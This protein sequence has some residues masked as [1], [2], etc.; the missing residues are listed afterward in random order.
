MEKRAIMFLCFLFLVSL[1][2]PVS[3]EIILSQPDYLYTIGDSLQSTI[4][5]KPV[6]PTNDFLTV[7]ISCGDESVE[8][9]KNQ[10][11]IGAGE[12]QEVSIN[13]VLSN[14]VV[15]QLYGECN[16][17]A[18]FG[19]ESAE[20]QIFILSREIIV[21]LELE[22]IK[23][24]PKEE[25]R[26]SGTAV[27]INGKKIEGFVEARIE[28]LGVVVS[29]IIK[30]GSFN[31]ILILPE[32][33]PAG[34]Y[35]LN[36]KAYDKDSLD[37]IGNQGNANQ[38]I[39]VASVLKSLEIVI[40][41]LNSSF[42]KEI[43]YSV[44]A[45]DQSGDKLDNKDISVTVYEPGDFEYL[46]QVL[47]SGQKSTIKIEKN[48]T[49]GFWKIEANA[50]EIISKKL[51]HIEEEMDAVFSLIGNTLVVTN[52]GNVP[53]FGNIEVE[54]GA[55]KEIK[56]ISLEIGE[57]KKFK[58]SAPEGEYLI[59]INDGKSEASLGST[60]LTGRAVGIDE[61]KGGTVQV[62]TNPLFWMLGVVLLVFIIVYII[63]KR[64]AGLPK[65]EKSKLEIDKKNQFNVSISGKKEEAIIVALSLKD[66]VNSK[67]KTETIDNSLNIG[68]NAGA[69]IYI[70]SNFRIILFSPSLTKLKENEINAIKAAERIR[71]I[72]LEHNKK[73]KEKIDFG[74]GI[75]SGQI[76]SENIGG[77]FKFTSIGN[78]IT[79]AKRISR[80]A[81]GEVLIS[82]SSYRRTAG[83]IKCE[84]IQS[85]SAWK[86]LGTPERHKHSEFLSRFTGKK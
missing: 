12:E 58:L 53:Y 36:I 85:K 62:L 11:N 64:Y 4:I 33:S 43:V 45:Y 84:K 16:L 37:S 71:D 18:N 65:K 74:I 63:K 75:N 57:T 61:I 30:E 68:K 17:N 5:L 1:I 14:S 2:Q 9:Y 76:I 48:T 23:Y 27:K 70:D 47:R 7:K 77:E 24:S 34:I 31:F 69:K 40:N 26:I 35:L 38:T 15:S 32:N 6:S 46:K 72:F 49:P 73:F 81:D 10:F 42:E 28:E 20:S 52:L 8:I 56:Q 51:F 86:I 25:I 60:F 13:N 80:V 44:I 39:E 59:K 83:V 41:H 79:E 78:I 54:I 22:K 82:E 19:Q 55:V 3:A 21:E 29:N 66:K 67:Y 50:G